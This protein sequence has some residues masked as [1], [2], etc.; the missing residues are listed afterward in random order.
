MMAGAGARRR[1]L[2]AVFP[3]AQLMH[4]QLTRSQAARKILALCAVS[5][6]GC[7]IPRRNPKRHGYV[8][9][10][11]SGMNY[12]A[13]RLIYEVLVGPI[14]EGLQIDHLCRKRPCINPL[15][16]EPVTARQN[17]LRGNTTAAQHAAQ[18]HCQDGHLFDLANTQINAAGHRHC[19]ECNRIRKRREYWANPEKHRL[20][21]RLA[22]SSRN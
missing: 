14:P 11:A 15:H 20:R 8:Y 18:T 13:H 19:R 21:N 7:W 5:E 22:Y 12:R 4:P 17:V 1:G 10:M 6:T 3:K 16:L 2:C 9:V